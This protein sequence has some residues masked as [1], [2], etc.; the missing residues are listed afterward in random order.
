MG[1]ENSSLSVQCAHKTIELRI[2]KQVLKCENKSKGN[3]YCVFVTVR[4]FIHTEVRVGN[5]KH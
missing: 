2:R 3:I 1:R 5:S 4:Y